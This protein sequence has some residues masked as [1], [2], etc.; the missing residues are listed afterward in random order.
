VLCAGSRMPAADGWRSSV[1]MRTDAEMRRAIGRWRRSRAGSRMPAADGWRSGVKM[2]TD[3]EMRRAIGRWRR[4]RAGDNDGDGIE[5]V[6]HKRPARLEGRRGRGRRHRSRGR[7]PEWEQEGS[8]ERA[9]ASLLHGRPTRELRA[10]RLA[11]AEVDSGTALEG[12]REGATRRWKAAGRAQ[13]GVRDGFGRAMRFGR[14]TWVDGD[15]F[16]CG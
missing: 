11:P 12:R 4:S 6:A 8:M 5:E 16:V 13:G 14:R 3:A 2:R 10:S 9:R 15:G 1:K 7:S